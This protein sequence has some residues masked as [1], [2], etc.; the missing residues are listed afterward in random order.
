MR[1]IVVGAGVVGFN[2]ALMLSQERHDV[3]VVEQS[4]ERLDQVRRKLDVMTVAGSGAHPDVLDEA[5][6]RQAGLVV[7]ATDIDEVNMVTC[8]TAKQMGTARTVA[9][10]RKEEYLAKSSAVAYSALGIDHI[11][12]PEI[13]AA[14]EI[15][16]VLSSGAAL[17]VEDFGA[18][19]IRM[20]EYKFGNSPIAGVPLSAVT[21]PKPCKIVAIVRPNEAIIPH[22]SDSLHPGDHVYLV[23]NR[24]HITDL[25]PL[26]GVPKGSGVPRNITIFGGGRIG[27]RLARMLERYNVSVKVVEQKRERCELLAAELRNARVICGDEQDL[28]VLREDAI[29]GTDA[30]VGI[31]AR[32]EL[33]ILMAL[34]A[35]QMGVPRSIAVFNEP[36]Y[37][38]LAE[39]FDLDAAISPLLLSA[40]AI[41]KFVRRG[42]VLSVALLEKQQA[43]ALELVATPGSPIVGRSLRDAGLPKGAIVGA[44]LRNGK[45][46]VPDGDT[47]IITG[48][49]VVVV[50]LP[51]SVHA[52]ERM[53]GSA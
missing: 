12:T 48:D 47:Q 22:G 16:N 7:A 9:R 28:D 2:A 1:V 18:G 44:I 41:L 11:V 51:E 4:P 39:R 42:Q 40:G 30:F 53:F 29:P 19:K 38:S 15:I 32:G 3:V 10:L 24:E 8:F 20:M 26:F 35:K 50:A 43:E 34:L 37:V 31:T 49:R 13:I 6:A 27:Y 21:F 36:E 52:I 23:A 33:N 17:A 46:A 14:E 45:A 25:E 5:G